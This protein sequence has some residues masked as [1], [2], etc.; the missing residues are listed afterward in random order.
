M[1]SLII[2]FVAIGITVLIMSCG[3][4]NNSLKK[5]TIKLEEITSRTDTSEGF[6]DI[7]MKIL[8][9]S[10]TDTSHIYIAKG[11]YK[12]QVVG[13]KIEVKSN[14]LN[15]FTSKGEMIDKDGF[16]YRAV[17]INTIGRES[18]QLIKALGELYSFPTTKT[19]TKQ[20]LIP[21]AFSLNQNIANLDIESYY[22]F[23]LFFEEQSEELYSEIYLNTNTKEKIIELFEKDYEYRKPLIKVFTK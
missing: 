18:D 14:I 20:I 17:K 12:G 22:K 6:S 9:D 4:S 10:K 2:Y 13:L 8:D 19:F 7:F 15:G 11:L 21:N 23:K 3:Q 5:D 16:T 1:K